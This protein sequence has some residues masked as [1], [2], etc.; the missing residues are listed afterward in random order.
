MSSMLDAFDAAADEDSVQPRGQHRE[1]AT[2]HMV[3]DNRPQELTD[4]LLALG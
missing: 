3:T 4:L 2:D 1:I